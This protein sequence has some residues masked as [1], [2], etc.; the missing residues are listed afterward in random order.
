M[1]YTIGVLG[2]QHLGYRMRGMRMHPS[3]LNLREVDGYAAHKLVYEDML[4]AGVDGI[5][6]GGDLFHV[7]EPSPESVNVALRVDDLRV[8]ASPDDRFIWRIGNGGNHDNGSGRHRSAVSALHRPH[9]GSY[10]VFPDPTRPESDKVTPH[11]GYYEIHQPDPDVP[12]Y[13]HLVSHNGLDPALAERGI[14]IDPQP[15]E[16]GVNLLF[17]HGIFAADG[18]LFGAD[19]RHG[20]ERVIPAQWADRGFDHYLLSDYHTLGPI[21]GFGP[22]DGRDRGQVWMTGS[23][24]SRGFSDDICGRGWLQVTLTDDGRVTV[25]PRYVWQRPQIDFPVIDAATLSVDE[26]DQQVRARLLAQTMTD[27]ESASL[28]GDGG[29]IL[30]Q[31]I[32]GASPSQKPALRA[33]AIEWSHLAGDAAFFG[34]S[35]INSTTLTARPGESRQTGETGPARVTDYVGEF[36]RRADGNGAVARALA[37]LNGSIRDRVADRTRRVLADVAVDTE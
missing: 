6:D 30:R 18:R 21:P 32:S 8:D 11:P 1:S 15:L 19:E 25:T 37:G 23:L 16:G 4:G 22:D 29:V 13:L 3:G 36:T 20:A 7:S 33:A 35:Y 17:A 9:L 27:P 14:V 2:C 24:C 12:L 34:V 31:R 28:T 5:V 26:I 10:T